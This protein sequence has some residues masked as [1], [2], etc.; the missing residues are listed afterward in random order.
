MTYV[1]INRFVARCGAISRRKADDLVRSGRVTLNGK[2]ARLGDMVDEGKDDVRL[3]GRV[4]VPQQSVTLAMYKPK[5][6]VSTLK[7]PQGRRCIGD[8][9]PKRLAGLF[10]VGRLDY[11]ATGLIL[12]T[13]D[14]EIAQ[15]LHHPSYRVPKTYIV[16]V[17]PAPDDEALDTMA[18]G[19]VLD[20]RK[21]LP[22][23]VER[24]HST[25]TGA[26][27]K[28]TLVQ[29]LKNQIK[30]MGACVGIRVVSIRRISVGDVTLKG[31]APGEIRPLTQREAR[32]IHNLLKKRNKP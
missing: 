11:D 6:V 7:D 14:G 30:R 16:E 8:L 2:R 29:G 19:V 25:R 13:N 28:I 20:G 23:A 12:L 10:P 1:R 31:M 22:A 18:S 27:L 26:K 17:R 32:F 5:G 3:D 15:A 4:L 24:I 21:T 9:I